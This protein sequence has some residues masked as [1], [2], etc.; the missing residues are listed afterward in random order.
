MNV[1]FWIFLNIVHLKTGSIL[2]DC[3]I[4]SHFTFPQLFTLKFFDWNLSWFCTEIMVLVW[5]FIRKSKIENGLA[6]SKFLSI[7]LLLSWKLSVSVTVGT[8][9]LLSNGLANYQECTVWKVID[10]FVLD[11]LMV[12]LIRNTVSYYATCQTNW[13]TNL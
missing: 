13:P 3:R 7:A 2:S 8:E 10:G 11:G 12:L 6:F 5:S 1:H 9:H 4:Y